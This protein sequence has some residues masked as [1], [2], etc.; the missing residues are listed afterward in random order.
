MPEKMN[1]DQERVILAQKVGRR[2]AAGVESDEAHAA[3]TKKRVE[4]TMAFLRRHQLPGKEDLILDVGCG[5]GRFASAFAKHAG[6]VTGIDLTPEALA[7]GERHI[8]SLGLT[9]V[10]FFPYDILKLDP[11]KLGWTGRFD[12]VFAGLVP[13]CMK[14]G[15]VQKIEKL[16]GKSC[17]MEAMISLIDEPGDSF[18]KEFFGIS[19][20]RSRSRMPAFERLTDSLKRRGC[21]PSVQLYHEDTEIPVT[22][23]KQFAG[24]TIDLFFANEIPGWKKEAFF[25]FVCEKA[26]KAGGLVRHI[27]RESGWLLWDVPYLQK[28]YSH[29]Q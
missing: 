1:S 16:T 10:D 8:R 25:R 26:E 22:D 24:E 7:A 29:V 27:K 11:E 6:H 5:A 3:R 12:L 2:I 28:Y 14:D 9:N 19:P 23:V 17:F 20:A 4:D 18:R 15:F 13:G 21:E